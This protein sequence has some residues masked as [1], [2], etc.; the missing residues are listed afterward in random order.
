MDIVVKNL[1]VKYGEN[2]IFNDFSASF[3]YGETSVIMG[4][5]GIGKT[6]LL[7]C[8]AD[9]LPYEGSVEG[10]DGVA[11]VF[12]DDRLIKGLT[13]YE[14][15]DFALSGVMEKDERVKNIKAVL[16]DVELIN[17]VSS[18][19][20]ELSGGEKKRV[21][22]ARAFLSPKKI[23][24]MD[25]PLNSLDLGLKSRITDLFLDLKSKYGKTVIT[26]THDVEDALS[27]ADKISVI[28]K[29]KEVYQY[30]FTDSPKGRDIY[31]EECNEVRKI[32]SNCLRT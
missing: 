25:E 2:V 7:N 20:T 17:K 29:G 12:Q 32:I 3:A 13:V 16:E 24:L 6:T 8:I 5:S 14:N 28:D 22:L 18:F 21:S 31:G 23:L 1:T 27:I 30:T 4:K 26:V 11:Y 9:L 19:P 10:V 15:L